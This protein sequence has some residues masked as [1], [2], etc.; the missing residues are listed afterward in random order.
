MHLLEKLD[1]LKSPAPDIATEHVLTH[2]LAAELTALAAFNDSKELSKSGVYKKLKADIDAVTFGY[3]YGGYGNENSKSTRPF[4][5]AIL[6]HL[7]NGVNFKGILET[8]RNRSLVSQADVYF[9]PATDIGC[10]R[11]DNRN[12]IR[13]LALELGY[14]Y[15]FATSHLTVMRDGIT[16]EK[17]GDRLG[18]EGNAIMSRLP[19]TNL[20]IIPLASDGDSFQGKTKRLGCEKVLVADMVT[21]DGAVTVVCLNMPPRLSPVGRTRILRHVIKKINEDKKNRPVLIGGDLK[22]SNYNC[23]SELFFLLSVI[24]KL[25]RDMKYIIEEHHTWPE[26]HFERSLFLMAR[27][28]GYD[29]EA[30]NEIGR[31]C[32]HAQIHNLLERHGAARLLHLTEKLLASHQDKLAFKHDWFL[33]NSCIKPSLSHQAERPKVISH[34]FCDGKAVSSHDPILLDFEVV[35]LPVTEDEVTL[36]EKVL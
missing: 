31:G 5:R 28:R 6:W 4:Y 11:S 16:I 25:Y 8:L 29:F 33:A 21:H 15:Y 26:K 13:D 20:S 19:L 12:V 17:N 10:R 27:R 35:P 22:T 14:H 30:Y 3:E 1:N 7:E 18:L 24:N 23:R 9:F 34:L 32:Y 2:K 36:K